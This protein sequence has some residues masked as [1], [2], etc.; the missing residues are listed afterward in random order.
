MS[1]TGDSVS[2]AVSEPEQPSVHEGEPNWAERPEYPPSSYGS[3]K[4][5]ENCVSATMSEEDEPPA[6]ASSAGVLQSPDLSEEDANVLN[7][8]TEDATLELPHIFKSIQNTLNS[9]SEMKLL[10]FKMCLIKHHAEY[11]EGQLDKNADILDIVDKMLERCG[12]GG[13][14]SITLRVLHDIKMRDLAEELEKSCRRLR[15][16]HDLKTCLKR[17]YECIF[18]G[19]ARQGTQSFLNYIYT[20]VQM[21]A[22]GNAVNREHEVRQAEAGLRPVRQGTAIPC[23][24]IFRSMPGHYKPVRNVLTTGIAGIGLTV[25]VQKYILDW[26]EEKP[27]QDIHFVFPVP[28]RELNLIKEDRI[29]M[30]DLICIFFPEMKEMDF[31]EKKDCRVLFI[32]DGLDVCKR[33]LHFQDN[34]KVTDIQ[35]KTTIQVLLTNLIQ[36][37]LLPSAHVWITSRSAAANLIPSA[38]VH[39][40]TELCGFNDDQKKAYFMQ[41]FK[42][43]QQIFQVLSR[44]TS[45]RT[46]HIMCHIPVFCWIVATVF[47]RKFA[48]PDRTVITTL[49]QFYTHYLVLQLHMKNQKYYGMKTG[50]QQWQDT[51]P[52]FVLKVAKFAFEQLEKDRFSFHEVDLREFGLARR[53]VVLHSGLCTEIYKQESCQ[54]REFCFVHQSLQE[55]LAALHVHYTFLNRN[56]NVLGQPLMNTFSKI[57]KSAPMCDLYKTAIE[58]AMQSENG[59]LDLFLRFLFG[60]SEHST[61]EIL[62][63]L[64]K[65]MEVA[66]QVPEEMINYIKKLISENSKPERCGN[67][68]HCLLELEQN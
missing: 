67:L 30:R 24:D 46:L 18:E 23:S 41:K 45:A 40:Y 43:P 68:A 13:A 52:D 20:D 10:L 26:T 33:P 51:D 54:E 9:L 17:R 16:Q 56:Q 55:Y 37:N 28:F 53:D 38:C 21:I 6:A 49:T 64:L 34:D 61:Q 62:R 57:F 32:L 66:P 22:D 47:E 8:T 15:L 27:N 11:F 63:G 42:D 60:L 7:S 35:Q 31:I 2:P 12:K 4:S 5:D 50:L 39:R 44:V 65:R 36:G 14:L 1:E 25:C 48:D 3:M 59:Q 29:S 58:R 19:I